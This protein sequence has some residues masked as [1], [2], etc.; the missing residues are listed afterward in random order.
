MSEVSHLLRGSTTGCCVAVVNDVTVVHERPLTRCTLLHR[1]C[2][3]LLPGSSRLRLRLR[4]GRRLRL[5]LR[6]VLLHLLR[7]RAATKSSPSAHTTTLCLRHFTALAVG[8][9]Y[10]TTS[11]GGEHVGKVMAGAHCQS[12]VKYLPWWVVHTIVT[13]TDANY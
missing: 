11:K 1:C 12:L 3:G 10:L 8:A 4:L 9:G 2:R 6:L 13:F 5:R 7:P